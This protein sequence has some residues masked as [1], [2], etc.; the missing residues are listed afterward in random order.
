VAEHAATHL[1]GQLRAHG[2]RLRLEWVSV[3]VRTVLEGV[4]GSDPGPEWPAATDELTAG[5]VLELG[6][7]VGSHVRGG[8][9]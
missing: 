3:E 2:Y 7:L 9:R 1:V 6:R 4:R 8:D 5:D